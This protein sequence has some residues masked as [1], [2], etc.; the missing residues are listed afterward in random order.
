MESIFAPEPQ[1]QHGQYHKLSDNVNEWEEQI[2]SLISGAVPSRLGLS[3]KLHWSK[4]D[5]QSGYGVGSVVL[6]GKS[7]TSV[8]VPIIVKQWHLAPLDTVMMDDKAY[9]LSDESLKEIFADTS[10]ADETISKRN[11]SRM[12]DS[13]DMYE[14][15]Y[16]PVG[17]GRYVYSS[18]K[19]LLENIE[20]TL[21]EED[22]EA[23]KKAASPKVLAA[24][25][26]NGSYETFSKLAS[27]KGNKK[28]KKSRKKTVINVARKGVNEYSILGNPEGVFDPVML[29]ADRPTMRKFVA[30]AVGKGEAEMEAVSRI[31]K[32]RSYQLQGPKERTSETL[33]EPVGRKL[34]EHGEIFLTDKPDTA[35][36]VSC[37]RFGVYAMKDPAG[38]ISH[39][40][41]FPDVIN[42]SGKKVGL[43]IFAGKSC[44]AVQPRLSGAHCPD[45]EVAVPETTPDVGKF[46]SLIHIDGKRALATIPFTIDSVSMYKDIKGFKVTDYYGNKASL[47]LSPTVQGITPVKQAKEFGPISGPNSFL[48]PQGM[49][50]FELNHLKKMS[51]NIEEHSK[52]AALEH[53]QNPLRVLHQNGIFIMK[54][55]GLDKY[56]SVNDVKFDFGSLQ[57]NELDFLLSSFGCPQSSLGH[58]KHAAKKCINGARVHGL[59]MP[60]LASEVPQDMRIDSYIR[61]LRCDLVKE[62][63]VM[64][65]GEAVD[66]ALSLGFINPDNIAKFMEAVPRLKETLSILSKLLIAT[67]LGMNSIPEEATRAA[68]DNILRV[69]Q[70][71]KRLGLNKAEA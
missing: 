48:V 7:G 62:A 16:P 21:W 45:H 11:I 2:H 19:S 54:G 5:D 10:I 27:K 69:V 49:H 18:E 39:G 36:A 32:T 17:G 71:L 43:K 65:E 20:D 22:I 28:G 3:V 23:F 53:D 52:H 1:F 29:N 40:Y 6:G 34:G 8:G 68:R 46:G 9:P 70:G 47:I 38:V 35:K 15:T 13:G 41:C 24:A 56:A 50:F 42:F 55:H 14:N 25:G 12:Y 31:E 61:S 60:K 63:S 67:R 57:E 64:D 44:A 58:V 66:A 59:E 30:R 37:D 51:E 4:V 26:K 33:S